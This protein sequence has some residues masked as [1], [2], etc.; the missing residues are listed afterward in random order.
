MEAQRN[1][2]DNGAINGNGLKAHWDL[3]RQDYTQGREKEGG[4]EWP[5]L[6]GLAKEYGIPAATIRSR[7]HR[8]KWQAQRSDFHADFM[9]RARE[10]TLEQLA[11]KAA[12][13][14]VQAFGVARAMFIGAARKLNQSL[15]GKEMNVSE[16]EKLLKICD[17]AHRMGRRALGVGDKAMDTSE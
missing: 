13:L 12:Q 14:D 6:E 3:I 15:E 5:T 2:H 16:Q 7:A 8:E 10:K 1:G 9:Q 4:L 11:E 17:L